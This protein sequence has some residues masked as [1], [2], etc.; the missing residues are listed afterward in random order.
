MVGN[1]GWFN[2]HLYPGVKVICSM[3]SVETVPQIFFFGMC[4]ARDQIQGLMHAKH[5]LC[6]RAAPPSSVLGV[7]ILSWV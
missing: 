7:L 5:M 4:G 6:C 1:L 3:H 2:L